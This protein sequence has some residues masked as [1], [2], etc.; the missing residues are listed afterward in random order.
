MESTENQEPI[1]T[2]IRE[3]ASG[4]ILRLEPDVKGFLVVQK[5]PDGLQTNLYRVTLEKQTDGTE[6]L[7]WAYLGPS[8]ESDDGYPRDQ[9]QT[10]A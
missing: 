10:S 2:R 3:E 4:E 5:L 8:K 1:K 9:E 7:H 6:E